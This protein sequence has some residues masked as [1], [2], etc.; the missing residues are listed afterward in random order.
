MDTGNEP[1]VPAEGQPAPGGRDPQARPNQSND[2]PHDGN[3]RFVRSIDTARR[4]AQAAELRAAGHTLQQIADELGFE[5]RSAA[6]YACLRALTEAVKGPGEELLGREAARL[7]SLFESAMDVLERDHITVSH[8]R[9][10]KDDN[11]QPILD[12]GPKL[13]AIDRLL[14]VR[15]SYRK[16]LGLDAPSRVS[17]DAQQLGD[18]INALLNRA[19]ADDDNST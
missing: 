16:L 14:R 4:D 9:I 19:A 17:V 1:P 7:D 2:R 12:D 11:G 8:G 13:A 3:G 10:V 15:E 5:S 6:R 18:E